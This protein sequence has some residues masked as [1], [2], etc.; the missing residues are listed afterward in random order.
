MLYS[1]DTEH[2]GRAA[3]TVSTPRAY[4]NV[5][6]YTRSVNGGAVQVDDNVIIATGLDYTQSFVINVTAAF[7]DSSFCPRLQGSTLFNGT[8]NTTGEGIVS[9]N[10]LLSFFPT[11]N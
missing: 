10:Y 9:F 5:V 1:V 6:T 2:S 4:G 7:G 8:F 11:Q 3:L